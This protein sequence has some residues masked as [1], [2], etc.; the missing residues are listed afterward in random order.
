MEVLIRSNKLLNDHNLLK[1]AGCMISLLVEA[2]GG[3]NK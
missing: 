3:P 2:S 1:A